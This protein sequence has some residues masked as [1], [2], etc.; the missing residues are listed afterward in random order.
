MWG[1]YTRV[2]MHRSAQGFSN[3]N[4]RQFFNR[5]QPCR[6]CCSAAPSIIFSHCR[7]AAIHLPVSRGASGRAVVFATNYVAALIYAASLAFDRVECRFT[8][9]TIASLSL[10]VSPFRGCKPVYKSRR[11]RDEWG[12]LGDSGGIAAEMRT[13][14]HTYRYQ[15]ISKRPYRGMSSCAAHLYIADRRRGSIYTCIFSLC[16]IISV[17]V[18]VNIFQRVSQHYIIDHP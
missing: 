12:S 16:P 14:I 3:K 13:E 9:G 4:K 1:K 8:G 15:K 2:I 11:R 17:K 10:A 5:K 6:L 18:I 7:S